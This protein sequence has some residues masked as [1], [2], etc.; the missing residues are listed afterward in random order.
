MDSRFKNILDGIDGEL[1][2]K[3]ESLAPE[4]QKAIEEKLVTYLP[5]PAPQDFDSLSQTL[6][7]I[8]IWE[9][10]NA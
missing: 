1:K 7:E 5:N 9:G 10:K 3:W 6:L 8:M 2:E 4:T